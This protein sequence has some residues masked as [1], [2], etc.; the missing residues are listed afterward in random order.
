MLR[1]EKGDRPP[2]TVK[3]DL[4]FWLD[5]IEALLLYVR[6]LLRYGDS[7]TL[8]RATAVTQRAA[9]EML[10]TVRRLRSPLVHRNVHRRPTEPSLEQL[11][12]DFRRLRNAAELALQNAHKGKHRGG[13]EAVSK[14]R[15]T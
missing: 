11:E 10:A 6:D 8:A 9:R 1:Y 15:K 3:N 4:T 5:A 13:V 2:A 7:A 12:N 14:L